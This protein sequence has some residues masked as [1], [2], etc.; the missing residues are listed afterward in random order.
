MP[1]WI[2]LL[3]TAAYMAV[4][5][6]VAWRRDKAATLPGFRQPTL[7][8]ALALGVYCTSWTF[9]GAVGTA[10]GDGWNFLPIYLGPAL[11]FLFLPSLIRRIGNIAQRESVSSLSDFLS[12]RY[13]KSQGVAV[14]ATLAA[15]TGSLPYI[16]LQ[17]QSVG[18][19][20]QAIT[21]ASAG[22][23]AE[24]PHETVLFTA[25]VLAAF[26]ILFGARQ[27][28]TTKHNAGLMQILAV[29][30]VI[31]LAA[32]FAVCALSIAML[33]GA[34]EPP[35]I[36]A[37]ETFGSET[38]S[39]RFITI[40]LL[41]MAAI[42]CLPRQ[43]HVAIVERR[44]PNEV[45]TARWAFP[46]YLALTSV[47]VIPITMA[48]LNMLPAGS[49][50]DL[51]VLSLPLQQG[52]GVLAML[53]FLGGFSAA[54]GMVIVSSIALS[55]MVTNDLIVPALMRTG[56]FDTI[57]GQ[58][59]ARL[60]TL[61]RTVI[62]LLLLLAFGFYRLTG[63]SNALAQ[64][65]LLS[66]AAAIQFA[67][68]L[69]G[70]I[71]WS[72]GH[73]RGVIAG[74]VIGIGVWAYTLLIPAAIGI[75]ALQAAVPNWANPHALFGIG[76]GD[77]L[78]H[79][80][81]FSLGLNT[82]VFVLVSLQAQ[83][84]LRD[85]VQAAAFIGQHRVADNIGF[86]DVGSASAITP[87]GLKA[88]AARF[89]NTNA[90]EH[91]FAA[92]GA[93]SG[94]PV[95]GKH[96][97][98]DSLIQHTEKLL[99]K[100]LGASSARVVISSAIGGPNVTLPDVLSILD[101]KTRS[102]RFERH[103]LQS[104]LENIDHGI[105][106]VDQE[107]RLVAWNS[108]YVDLFQYP[109]EL[110]V[111]GA[112]VTDL[113]K[114]NLNQ[115][116]I[117][118]DPTE[119]AQRRIAHMQVGKR[120]MLEREIPDGR[121]LRIIG[122]PMP[123]GGYVTSFIDITQDKLKEQALIEANE[124]LEDR[125]AERTMALS[126]MASD[127]DKARRDAE[128]ANA[129]K[130][131]FLAAASHDLLQP[132]NAARLLLGAIDSEPDMSPLKREDLLKKADRSI[133]SADDLL[134]GL[135]D[136]SRLDHG[137]ITA[138]PVSVQLGPLFEDLSD[139]AAPMAAEAGLRLKV[140]ATRLSVQADPGFLESILRNFLS[141]ARR[142]TREGGVLI[143]ARRRG[144]LVRI[145]VWDTGP[146]VPEYRQSELFE[147]FRRFEDIDN[148]GLRGAGLGLS[149]AKRLAELMGSEIG[150]RSTPGRGSMFYVTCPIA[151]QA[152][153][154][155]KPSETALAKPA[156]ALTGL[157]V[158]CVD[159]EPAILDATRLLLQTWGCE[160]RLAS[161]PSEAERIAVQEPIDVI[162][163]DLDLRADRD[164]IEL[165]TG[166]RKRL[167][168]PGNIAIITAKSTQ[169]VVDRCHQQGLHLLKKPSAPKEIRS[170]LDLCASRLKAQAAE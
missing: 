52:D 149:I 16:A 30:A 148:A 43:F 169:S 66:F 84:R 76:M 42:I 133:K 125:V 77:P 70:A 163:A 170:F 12:A 107:Q 123:G 33:S 2:V 131:R 159:D 39:G 105:S 99:A 111:V 121:Y 27:S 32:L 83:S 62:V 35:R 61:R 81:V 104:M 22:I 20:F 24:P 11:I 44:E 108:A 1:T 150:V 6:A 28:D 136:I 117:D 45:R 129:S 92:F 137:A 128:G 162:I 102:E 56:R 155:E 85:L 38:L 75:E 5:F 166:L 74:L 67:P 21:G 82:A 138:K 10:A 23:A 17:L 8:Y 151:G 64:I 130:T 106:V 161:N 89:L 69:I 41:S 119:Q 116:W 51:F 144:D 65:G 47:V 158:L 36:T 50:P 63:G 57:A 37:Q 98:D 147:E 122:N 135:L 40:T 4:L 124:S 78:T 146:G 142:Y 7:T 100:A 80:V 91:A 160:P 31:K 95:T 58:S 134:K 164:G 112:A 154:T 165:V 115:G 29:E 127:L 101:H 153:R 139:E 113:I 97:A 103:M 55:T 86:A 19:S 152:P 132:L 143:G 71:T 168:E 90:V 3:T 46:I 96:A 93:E 54:M 59:G 156:T 13:G 118:G 9:F 72:R 114:H 126:K 88:L 68:A 60:L 49:A 87:E 167:S 48:G 94:V 15:V 141:N 157:N 145:E 14:I 73:R 26:A 53:V 34:T 79:G 25:L 18:M 110:V 120:H 140:V 109:S